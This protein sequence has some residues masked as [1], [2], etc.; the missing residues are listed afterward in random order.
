MSDLRNVKA[1]AVHMDTRISRLFRHSSE[2]PLRSRHLLQSLSLQNMLE[3]MELGTA[4][5]T[6]T[7]KLFDMVLSD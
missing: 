1:L 5:N 7:S 3:T 4:M 6:S 2:L